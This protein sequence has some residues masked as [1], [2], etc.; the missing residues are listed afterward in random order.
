MWVHWLPPLDPSK[1][2]CNAFTARLQDWHDNGY[3]GTVQYSLDKRPKG[4]WNMIVGAQYALDRQWHFRVETTFLNGRTTFL[5]AST[6]A[7]SSFTTCTPWR[8]KPS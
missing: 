7:A 2:L 3:D 1:V 4:V 5:A 8:F 6:A